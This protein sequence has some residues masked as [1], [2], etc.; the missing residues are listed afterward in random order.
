MRDMGEDEAM[1]F[2]V[3]ECE[4]SFRSKGR[5]SSDPEPSI[6]SIPRRGLLAKVKLFQAATRRRLEKVKKQLQATGGV[7]SGNVCRSVSSGLRRRFTFASS[8]GRGNSCSTSRTK[9]ILYK[10]LLHQARHFFTTSVYI[11]FLT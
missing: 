11:Q 6:T 5:F 9:N 7:H 3:Q 10:F 8:P 1:K 2:V 4:R